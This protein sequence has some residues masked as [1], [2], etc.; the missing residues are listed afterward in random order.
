[1]EV[2]PE[3]QSERPR[4]SAAPHETDGRG[5]VPAPLERDIE[6]ELVVG[7]QA[8]IDVL[9]A[10]IVAMDQQLRE[11]D[12]EVRGLQTQVKEHEALV[13][14]KTAELEALQATLH[15]THARERSF[16]D[17]I[18]A[19]DTR[20]RELEAEA[21]E[22]SRTLREHIESLKGLQREAARGEAG[23]LPAE[24]YKMMIELESQL[25]ESQ[26]A[27]AA[28]REEGR[29]LE[30]L[31]KQREA[32]FGKER[33]E[34][35][36]RLEAAGSSKHAPVVLENRVQDLTRQLAEALEENR[37]LGEV[38]RAKT[39]AIEELT[40]QL[41][42]REASGE[43]AAQLRGELRQREQAVAL[44]VEENT[45]LVRLVQDR[46]D[47]LASQTRRPAGIPVELW[48]GEREFLK[49]EVARF[50]EHNAALEATNKRQQDYISKL[51]ERI[52][53]AGSC[54]RAPGSPFTPARSLIPS[55]PPRAAGLL[56]TPPAVAA[57]AATTQLMATTGELSGRDDVVPAALH[58]RLEEEVRRLREEV[59]IKDIALAERDEAATWC[60]MCVEVRGPGGRWVAAKVADVCSGCGAGDLRL[61]T[62]AYGLLGDLAADRLSVSWHSVPCAV[63]GSLQYK[64]AS[65]SSPSSLALQIRNSPVAVAKLEVRPRGEDQW[66][67]MKRTSDNYFTADFGGAG[68]ALPA[69]L[70]TTACNKEQVT[71]VDVLT[72]VVK[73]LVTTG[74]VQFTKVDSCTPPAGR[75][76]AL[77]ASLALVALAV[78]GPLV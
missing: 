67:E 20:R 44:L 74:S 16:A 36:R 75:A 73:G 37:L 22:L 53:L 6:R 50:K 27:Q 21:V 24:F 43:D 38:Q 4:P 30:T 10:Q 58:A 1:M 39:K 5:C 23:A 40:A 66:T 48:M 77:S 49:S 45:K 26:R 60:G 35:E 61:S 52:A 42:Q 56:G 55:P 54:G 32:A 34:L 3:P 15:D 70:R 13:A 7:Q 28:L 8:E 31:L 18:G 71:D 69:S 2:P 62:R 72:V 41:A 17:T 68:I 59:R 29:S 78:A 64:A 11:R 25:G 57:A 19:S 47:Q 33:A 12:I 65:S 51:R 63:A 46:E 76:Q 14:Q 9:Y